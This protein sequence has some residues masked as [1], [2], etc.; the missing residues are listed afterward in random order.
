MLFKSFEI[1]KIKRWAFKLEIIQL[2][3]IINY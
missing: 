2:V 3:I 1:W